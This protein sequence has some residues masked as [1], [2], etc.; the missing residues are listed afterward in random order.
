MCTH[1]LQMATLE[2]AEEL[3]EQ[4]RGAS[5]DAAV[6]DLQAREHATGRGGA[7]LL[8][9]G[10]VCVSAWGGQGVGGHVQSAVPS[11]ELLAC[12][13]NP[14]TCLPSCR[15][16]SHLPEHNLHSCYPLQ[17]PLTSL[18]LHRSSQDIKEFAAEQ[19]FTQELQ[20]A[21]KGGAAGGRWQQQQQQQPCGA[22]V[23]CARSGLV[24]T[25]FRALPAAP[26][27]PPPLSRACHPST[28]SA[29]HSPTAAVGRE[30]LG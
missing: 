26:A 6:R 10:A 5:Y 2:K 20:Q 28:P 9:S 7:A 22:G 8:A 21:S 12:S 29:T 4:L 23:V 11:A 13:S 30:L 15:A 24:A 3:L 17:S 16:L 14:S 1:P 27:Q 18:S 25:Q 19:G